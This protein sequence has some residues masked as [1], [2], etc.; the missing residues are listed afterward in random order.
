MEFISKELVWKLHFEVAQITE[1]GYKNSLDENWITDARNAYVQSILRCPKNLQWKVW[2]AGGRTEVVAG[3]YDKAK[4]LIQR[5]LQ[6]VPKKSR[7]TVLLDYS[8]L[9]EFFDN[10]DA[11]REILQNARINEKR[12][13]KVFLESIMLEIRSNNT[14]QAIANCKLALEVHPGTGRLWALLIQL[15]STNGHVQ[16]RR[17]FVQALEHVPKS[18]EVWCQGARLH[19]NPFSA[20]FDLEIAR[21]YLGFAIR[22]TPQYGDSF[23]ELLRLDIITKYLEL[24]SE[25]EEKEEGR[26]SREILSS[27]NNTAV[28][29]SCINAD[30]NYG[31]L[32]FHCKREIFDTA[33]QVLRVAKRLIVDEL[34][35][36]WDIYHLA[37]QLRY[38]E[39]LDLSKRQELQNELSRREAE[40]KSYCTFSSALS[41]VEWLTLNSS[42]L[43]KYERRKLLFFSDLIIL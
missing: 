15:Q 28:E 30:P 41:S 6:D 37:L 4:K 33:K 31:L 40:I 7:A 10:L 42:R 24:A 34:I 43:T 36:F 16:Q 39:N 8:R 1:R 2:L 13:W 12:D 11:A 35:H 25:T 27:L 29:L 14:E 19:L 21:K 32:F 23:I 26:N 5:A 20:Q 38:S 3:N 18:G 22:F 17:S 9:E